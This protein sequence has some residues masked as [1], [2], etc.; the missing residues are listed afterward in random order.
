MRI[1]EWIARLW[2]AQRVR[3]L[4]NMGKHALEI[5][6]QLWKDL[7]A[8]GKNT[9]FGQEHDFKNITSI[10]DFQKRVPVRSYED[11]LPWINRAKAGELNV[12][13]KGKARYFAKTSGTTAGAKFLPIS[14]ESIPN[15][16]RGARDLLLSAIYHTG[17]ADFLGGKMLFLSGSPALEKLPSQIPVGRLSGIVNHWIP[18]YLKTNQI[19]DY[20]TNCIEGWEEKIQTILKQALTVDLRFISGIP[21]WVLQFL[22]LAKQKTGKTPL[23]LWPN[24]SL[25]V[26]GGVDFRPYQPMFDEYFN[27]K[28]TI[29]ETFPASEGFFAIQDQP[30][31]PDLLLLADNG[32]AYEFI[33]LAEYGK[34]DAPRLWL[35]EV[36]THTQYAMIISTNSGLW[37]Y[38]IGDT[39]RFTSLNPPRIRVSGRVK[40]FL[41]A[42][43]EHIIEEE[44]N[45]ALTQALN[46]T[47]SKM[48][49]C[50]VAPLVLE[51]G[52]RHD[53]FIEFENPPLDPIYFLT[54]LDILL[55]E[56]NPYYDDL[57][58]GNILLPPRL[59]TLKSGACNEYMRSK[60]RL[61]GQN[62]FN[63]LT[64]SRTIASQLEPFK[65]NCY[66]PENI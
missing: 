47:Q 42:F 8:I 52:F 49:D 25:Y 18:A 2:A 20:T 59:F 24:L 12:L 6:Q 22:D 23:Q 28:V 38:D 40:Q 65:I 15:H 50:T 58:K 31:K 54:T 4:T 34:P 27:Q 37:A 16:I 48:I 7:I 43:G 56:Q 51:T 11:L 9:S 64:N 63:R 60:G 19:P 10:S 33:P 1:K 35:G 55:R 29:L 32:I 66:D 41:S 30:D 5:Q 17:S 36:N 57:R 46:K 13:W 53:W 62:K 14:T 21:P 39:V 44:V 61:G 26:Q 3:S 45:T